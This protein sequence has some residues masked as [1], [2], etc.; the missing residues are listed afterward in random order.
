LLFF[1]LILLSYKRAAV[2]LYKTETLAPGS[3]ISEFKHCAFSTLT[4]WFTVLQNH[5]S[6]KSIRSKNIRCN[7]VGYIFAQEQ[8]GS[9]KNLNRRFFTRAFSVLYTNFLIA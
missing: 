3:K 1:D 9:T 2:A 4:T 6:K 7:T 5:L 8:V